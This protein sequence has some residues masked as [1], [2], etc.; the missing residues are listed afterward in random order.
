MSKNP[1]RRFNLRLENAKAD[2]TGF[3]ETLISKDDKKSLLIFLLQTLPN[4][5]IKLN[6]FKGCIELY[7]LPTVPT[8]PFDS[9]EYEDDPEET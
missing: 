5:L 9:N 8:E 4:T 6:K 1:I 7:P 2:D 3:I